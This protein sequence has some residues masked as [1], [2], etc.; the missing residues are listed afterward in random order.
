MC[1]V[2]LLV[3]AFC[4]SHKSL[5]IIVADCTILDRI[6]N[7]HDHLNFCLALLMFLD[8]GGVLVSTS[9]CVC[10]CVCVCMCICV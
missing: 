7:P 8:I 3:V 1:G 10:V 6:F 4:V 2:A 5:R 9:V